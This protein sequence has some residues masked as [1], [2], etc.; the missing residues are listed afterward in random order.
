VITTDG[1]IPVDVTLSL[2]QLRELSPSLA[3]Q[4]VSSFNITPTTRFEYRG[5]V[6]YRLESTLDTATHRLLRSRIT[7]Q[8]RVRVTAKDLPTTETFQIV[9]SLTQSA[10]LVS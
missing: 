6:S 10:R 4:I 8:V 1:Q 9:S 2:R 5:L 7:G 3:S